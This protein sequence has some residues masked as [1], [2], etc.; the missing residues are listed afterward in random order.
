MARKLTGSARD[1]FMGALRALASDVETWLTMDNTDPGIAARVDGLLAQA[2]SAF[3][4]AHDEGV[5]NGRRMAPPATQKIHAEVVQGAQFDV[6]RFA[7]EVR[8]AV[9]APIEVTVVLATEK[10]APIQY[11]SF[12]VGPFMVK[13]TQQ[14]GESI[15]QVYGRVM[16]ELRKLQAEEFRER[17][18]A[19][20]AMVKAAAT[21]AR[22]GR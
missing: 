10:F 14:P 21:S 12:D 20:L 3:K 6:Q 9:A 13:T 15:A 2:D 7:D 17:L 8:G 22:G 1:V 5:D 4:E 16:P 18:P 19:H 11:H